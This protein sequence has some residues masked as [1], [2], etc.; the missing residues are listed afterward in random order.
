MKIDIEQGKLEHCLKQ[1]YIW[2]D[3]NIKY[4]FL[5]DIDDENGL[6]DYLNSIWTPKIDFMYL[7]E[8][9]EA[10]K[11]IKVQKNNHISPILSGDIEY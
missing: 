3:S 6:D 4:H 11:R 9:R 8:N 5:S 2:F 7:R 1:T 10:F